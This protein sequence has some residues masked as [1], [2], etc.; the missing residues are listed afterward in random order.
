MS[1]V[2]ESFCDCYETNGI[3]VS[4]YTY[5]SVE[6]SENLVPEECRAF[7]PVEFQRYQIPRFACGF[8]KVCLN[9]TTLV[10][11]AISLIGLVLSY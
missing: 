10:R 3:V 11:G 4:Y 6:Y 1:I 9:L 2:S 8:R 7:L 5:T